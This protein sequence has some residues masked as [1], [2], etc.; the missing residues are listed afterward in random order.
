MDIIFYSSLSLGANTYNIKLLNRI[1]EIKYRNDG[2]LNV[3][4]KCV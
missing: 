4:T 2:F 1:E 3:H